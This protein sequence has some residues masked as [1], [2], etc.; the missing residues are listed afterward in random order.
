MI[1]KI[2]KILSGEE[3]SMTNLGLPEDITLDHFL[4]FQYVPITF[5]DVERSISKYK[6]LVTDNCRSKK[7]D[8]IKKSLLV[9]CNS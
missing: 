2:S 6:N 8:N 5:T 4:Y 1:C 3:E 7:L 9:Q